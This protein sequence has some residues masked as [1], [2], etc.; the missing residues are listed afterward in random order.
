MRR[1]GG[2]KEQ[3]QKGGRDHRGTEGNGWWEKNHKQ[4]VREGEGIGEEMEMK[5]PEARGF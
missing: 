5:V 2:Q 1:K 4:K 3:E